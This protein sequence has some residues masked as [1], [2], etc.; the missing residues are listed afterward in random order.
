MTIFKNKKFLT[1]ASFVLIFAVALISI[2]I[3]NSY[4]NSHNSTNNENGIILPNPTTDK[5]TTSVLNITGYNNLK[6]INDEDISS[7]YSIPDGLVY[8]S[9]VYLSNMIESE[10]EVACFKLTDTAY[11]AQL[12]EVIR[13]HINIRLKTLNSTSD[14]YKLLENYIVSQKD[15][16]VFVSVGKNANLQSSTFNNIVFT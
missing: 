16:F 6:K 15:E 4:Y 2:S 5:I 10:E 14:Q 8:E 9:T 11:I 3:Y 7:Y 1:I 12:E 13:N